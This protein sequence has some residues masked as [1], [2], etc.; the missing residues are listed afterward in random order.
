M[1]KNDGYTL[2]EILIATGVLVVGLAAVF[3][4][5]QSAQKRSVAASD[6]SEVQLQCQTIL[7]EQLAKQDA[8]KPFAPRSMDA[9]RNWRIALNI[10]PA[11]KPE[12]SVLHLTAQKFAM[13]ENLPAGPTYHLIRWIPRHRV[14][15]P[16]EQQ[17]IMTEEREFD[18]PYQ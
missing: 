17:S 15:L 6:L 16:D 4:V 10:Y 11:P 7:N 3:G 9:L 13:P 5:T 1:N 2:L 18:D 12:L 8:I 14:Q